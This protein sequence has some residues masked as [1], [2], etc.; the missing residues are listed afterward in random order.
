MT[1]V[2]FKLVLFLFFLH[3]DSPNHSVCSKMLMRLKV[4]T[5]R[6]GAR[7]LSTTSTGKGPRVGF[8]GL[9]NMGASMATNLLKTYPNL[10]V[11]DIVPENV[12]KLVSLG[13]TAASSPSSLAKES[14]VIITMVPATSHV[15]SLLQGSNGLFASASKG[16]LFIDSSTIDP[17]ASKELIGEAN[18]KGFK[19]IDAPVVGNNVD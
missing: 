16:T 19:M 10:L 11:Y 15:R 7:N 6:G 17:L 13:A 14:D 2:F 9:G 4:I 3:D 8:I 12:S 5:L 18:S 1:Q